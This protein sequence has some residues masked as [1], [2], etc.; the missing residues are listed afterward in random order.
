M[1][2][3]DRDLSIAYKVVGVRLRFAPYLCTIT[4]AELATFSEGSLFAP[5]ILKHAQQV[6]A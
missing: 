5:R 4:P 1:Q 3:S 2:S 6:V